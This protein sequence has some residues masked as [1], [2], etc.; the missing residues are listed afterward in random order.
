MTPERTAIIARLEAATGP[1]RELDTDI[2]LMVEPEAT[3]KISH[4]VHIASGTPQTLDETR[5]GDGR[6]ITVPNFT[7]SLDAAMTLVPEGYW[8]GLHMLGSKDGGFSAAVLPEDTHMEWHRGATAHL[9]LCIAA[10]EARWSN[11]R[12]AT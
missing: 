12:N 4:Y 7:G 2:W 1:D 11:E 9:A 5:R 8:W 6:L 10:L 3:R